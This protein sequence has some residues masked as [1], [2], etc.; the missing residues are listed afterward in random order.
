MKQLLITFLI[1]INFVWLFSTARCKNTD[2]EIKINLTKL[3]NG[4]E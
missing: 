1:R 4:I 2:T 3:L